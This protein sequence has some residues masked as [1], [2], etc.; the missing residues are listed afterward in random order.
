MS[1]HEVLFNDMQDSNNASKFDSNN[2]TEQNYFHRE[3]VVGYE[4]QVHY[5]YSL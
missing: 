2:L 4:V 3:S 5:S 1:L